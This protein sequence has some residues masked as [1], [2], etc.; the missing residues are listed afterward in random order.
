MENKKEL[1]K[2]L[3]SHQLNC[4]ARNLDGKPFFTP[5]NAE[6]VIIKVYNNGETIPLCR[7]SFHGVVWR[8]N[9]SLKRVETEDELHVCPYYSKG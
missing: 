2:L 4:T 5:N 1:E 9:P 3:T 6:P 8:C 7:Y